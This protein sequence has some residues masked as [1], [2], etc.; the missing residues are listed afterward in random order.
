MQVD[1][2]DQKPQAGDNEDKKSE[3]E[4]M[5]VTL[6]WAIGQ[7]SCCSVAYEAESHLQIGP[8]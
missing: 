3:A 4:E 6:C 1:H 5:E 8:L 2:E 7:Y